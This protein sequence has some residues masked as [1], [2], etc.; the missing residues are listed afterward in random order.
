MVFQDTE[1]P[2]ADICWS[3]NNVK[4][5]VATYERLVLLF[6]SEGTRRDKFATKPADPAAGKKSYVI[7][8]K[9]F[10]EIIYCYVEIFTPCNFLGYSL[11]KDFI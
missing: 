5:A 9:Q 7:T 8:S 1:S 11:L 3:P 10:N 4:F 2:I 6:D